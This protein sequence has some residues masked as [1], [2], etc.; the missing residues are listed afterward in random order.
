M[1]DDATNIVSGN[2]NASN[3]SVSSPS[4][5]YSFDLSIF[6]YLQIPIN[7]NGILAGNPY[8]DPVIDGPAIFQTLYDFG[9]ITLETYQQALK[10]CQVTGAPNPACDDLV[11][12]IMAETGL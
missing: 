5:S 2:L 4:R 8:T 3:V 11:E 6:F 12:T 9:S 10:I 7:L 1:I